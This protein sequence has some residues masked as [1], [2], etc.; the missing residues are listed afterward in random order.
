M[1]AMKSTGVRN[2]NARGSECCDEVSGFCFLSAGAK[3]TGNVRRE[4]DPF[5]AQS[6]APQ[7]IKPGRLFCPLAGGRPGLS[8]CVSQPRPMATGMAT[9]CRD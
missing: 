7:R 9:L 4:R 5:A 3:W 6:H 2:V 1:A 8:E